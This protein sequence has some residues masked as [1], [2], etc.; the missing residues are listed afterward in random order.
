MGIPPGPWRAD[1]TRHRRSA[2]HGVEDPPCC[3]I[4]PAPRRAGPTWRHFLHAQ[5]AGILAAE[6]PLV[7][8]ALT[9][10]AVRGRADNGAGIMRPRTR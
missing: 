6:A 2:V 10:L 4:D 1:E 5:A 8:G 7:V 3:G 9:G